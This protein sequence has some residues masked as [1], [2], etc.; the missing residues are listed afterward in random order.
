MRYDV[1]RVFLLFDW[2]GMRTGNN[3]VDDSVECFSRAK[4]KKKKK[5]GR[6]VT[7]EVVESRTRS[8]GR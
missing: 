6:A 2:T 5:R 4:K 1:A 3:G 8:F 7:G